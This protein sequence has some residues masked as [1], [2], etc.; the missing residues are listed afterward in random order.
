[1]TGISPFRASRYPYM[2]AACLLLAA[3]LLA[4]GGDDTG[5][6]TSERLLLLEAEAHSLEESLETLHEEDEAVLREVTALRDENAALTS[7]LAALQQAQ[8][9]FVKRLEAA[10]AVREH[11]SEVAEFEEGQEQQLAALEDGQART[12]ERL[13]ELDG[14]LLELESAASQIESLLSL[15]ESWSTD[16]DQKKELSEKAEQGSVLER[17]AALAEDSGGEVYHIDLGEPE[18]RAILVM[19]PEPIDGNPLIVSLHGYGSNSVYHSDSFPLHRQ[20]VSRGFG[21]LLPNGTLDGSGNQFWNPTD[22]VSSTSKASAD[23]YAY[24]SSLVARAKELKDF[25]PVYVFGYSNG[26]FMAYHLACKGLPGLRAVASL[27]G[28]SYMD[29]DACEGAPPVSVLHIHGSAD[30]VILYSGDTAEPVLEAD[31]EPAAYASAQ[32]MVMRWGNRAGCEW[33]KTSAEFA[34]YAVFDLDM[35]VRGPETYAYRLE[36]GCADGIDIQLW[37]GVQSGHTPGYLH[38][39][40]EALLDWLLSQE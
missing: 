40:L 6:T 18:E 5:S 8:A 31:A 16:K 3:F 22:Q 25:G 23:D 9:D 34:H 7:E 35:F 10:E 4:C 20:V 13:E 37:Q 21:L 12:G 17:T 38:A 19:P 29:D 39:F 28:T 11:E 24:L 32:E 36:S 30:D 15:I 14:R 2:V 26:G 27:A 1:M 33:P